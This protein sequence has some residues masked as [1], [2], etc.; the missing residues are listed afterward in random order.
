L[1]LPDQELIVGAKQ[2]ALL[3]HMKTL[4]PPLAASRLVNRAVALV[5]PK[6]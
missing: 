1:C 6:A 5:Q 2:A 4:I 3:K